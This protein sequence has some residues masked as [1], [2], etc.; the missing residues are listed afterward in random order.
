MQR[1]QSVACNILSAPRTD[2][3]SSF[4]RLSPVC[5]ERKTACVCVMVAEQFR[6]CFFWWV[7]LRV[8]TV[9][10]DTEQASQVLQRLQVLEQAAT[11]QLN[12]RRG[13]ERSL[14]EAQ[15][16]ITQLD[17]ALQQG[18][19]PGTAAG[20]VVDTRVLG[21]PDKWDGSEK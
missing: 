7:I 18:G 15:T 1:S 13:A 10:M 11:Q 3:M 5:F 6:R 2:M 20:Q 12:A 17:Q 21:R 14:V 9:E 4:S 8:A 16:R 19:R